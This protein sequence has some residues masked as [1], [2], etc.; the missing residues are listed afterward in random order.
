LLVSLT[1]LASSGR[2]QDSELV[3]LYQEASRAQADGDFATAARKYE[4]IVVIRPDLAE[5]FA[6]LGNAYFQLGKPDRAAPAYRKAIVLKPGLAGPHFFLGMMSFQQHSYKEAL[7]YL[8]R[9]AMLQPDNP[10]VNSYLGYTH[11]ALGHFRQAVMRL[12]Q[13]YSS[14]NTDQDVVYHLSKS[15]GRL[16]EDSFKELKRRFPDSVYAGLARAHVQETQQDWKAASESYGAA[17][18]KMPGNARLQ[19]KA[20][21]AAQK[22]AEKDV[23]A[24]PGPFDATVDGSLRYLYKPPPV[25]ALEQEL[26]DSQKK[27]QALRSQPA[28]TAEHLYRAGEGYQ[29]LAYLASLR[30]I[31]QDSNSFRAHLLQAQLMEST[32]KE[33]DAIREY[34]EVLR[35]EPKLPNVHFAIGSLLW[36][37]QRFKEAETELLSELIASPNH[38][39]ALYELGDIA[40]TAGDKKAAEQYFL[41]A[42]K[43]GPEIVEAHFALEKI[44]TSDG[45]YDKS[46]DH[47]RQAIK[48]DDTDPTP[49]YRLSQVYRRMGKLQESQAELDIFQQRK[50]QSGAKN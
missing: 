33:E 4:R 3:S 8:N 50:S 22:A 42:L 49:H 13:A 27:M 38:P 15:Y 5:A 7:D 26:I 21:R 12:E 41:H 18:L 19:T 10:G 1:V 28:S 16:A 30:V 31:A 20:A 36:K 44:Y 45:L 23:P 35:L 39:Q 2:G 17:L 34:R 24:D 29:I 43:H 48:I 46:L 32:G 11:Y 47:L 9:A 14:D 25:E 40:L 6:N 37:D